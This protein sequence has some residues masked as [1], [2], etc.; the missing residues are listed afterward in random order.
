MTLDPMRAPSHS[1]HRPALRQINMFIQVQDA[2]TAITIS[3]G[4]RY[5]MSSSR[6][7]HT[8]V[9]RTGISRL[10]VLSGPSLSI[11]IAFK[12]VLPIRVIVREL[13]EFAISVA[14]VVFL[15]LQEGCR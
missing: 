5:D 11:I 8:A 10:R 13:K 3:Y 4:T 9:R 6:Y 7:L 14:C 2:C 12:W 1:A 15:E